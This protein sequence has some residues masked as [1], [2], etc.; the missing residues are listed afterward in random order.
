MK[1]VLTIISILLFMISFSGCSLPKQLHEKLLIQGIAL[2]KEDE[3][4]NLT[5][6][7]FEIGAGSN[8]KEENNTINVVTT[9]GTSVT[10]AFDSLIAKT[11]KEPLYSQNLLLV[12]GED[13]AKNG[14]YDTI[15]FF[16]RHYESRPT[17]DVFI[18]Q[19]K[20]EDILNT[21]INDKLFTAKDIAD[22]STA[23]DLN[24]C[25]MSSDLL[26][27]VGKLKGNI[28]DPSAAVLL[29]DDEDQISA[30]GTALF[31]GEKLI[32]YLDEN[33][34]KGALLIN[35]KVKSST[36]VIDVPKLGK[37]SYNITNSKS[38][39]VV[40]IVDGLPRFS[41]NI[42]ADANILE[43]DQSNNNISENE[44]SELVLEPAKIRIKELAESAIK[45]TIIDNKSDIFN[46]GKLLKNKQTSYYRQVENELDDILSKSTYEITVESKVI[47]AGK[48]VNTI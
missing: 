41:I 10:D 43:I 44:L 34:S 28:S 31:K 45:K 25:I 4:Y 11:G 46:F 36:E 32:S 48:E 8:P 16:I 23:E 27:F 6:Q 35:K 14:I 22:L 33:E 26:T 12:I 24:S 38:K 40:D 47:K 17:I 13:T 19:G 18:S 3:I 37:V 29:K 30:K 42:K 5:V 21:K 2:D 1:R 15:D 20:A 39:I 7:I 9:K